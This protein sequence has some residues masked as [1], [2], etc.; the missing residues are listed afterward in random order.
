MAGVHAELSLVVIDRHHLKKKPKVRD[1]VCPQC[2]AVFHSRAKLQWHKETHD[3]KPKACV[4]CSDKF[5]HAASLT[6]HVRRSH[7]EYFMA[8]TEK[9]KTQNVPCPV[10]K[11]VSLSWPPQTPVTPIL[12]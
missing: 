11:Q 5:V 1:F 4:Y 12:S 7:N 6:R 8:S 3:E 2:G 10:C 9:H